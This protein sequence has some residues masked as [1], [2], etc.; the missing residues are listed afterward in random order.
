MKIYAGKVDELKKARD[1]WEAD[2]DAKEAA[3]KQQ[4]DV[5]DEA[6]YAV[7]GP[8]EDKLKSDLS[9]FNLLDFE[10]S[11]RTGYDFRRP[12]KKGRAEHLTIRIECNER[13]KF[14]DSS[15]LSWSFRVELEGGEIVKQ[16]NSWSGL[17]ATTPEQLS[18]L[19]QTV[20][21]LEYLQSVNWEEIVL[22]DLPKRSDYITVEQPSRYGRPDFELQ[23]AEA[24]IEDFIGQ[25]I[26]VKGKGIEKLDMYHRNDYWYVIH[27]ETPKKYIISYITNWELDAFKE[28]GMSNADIVSKLLTQRWEYPIKKEYFIPAVLEYYPFETF[29]A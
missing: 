15:A 9:K 26:L 8:I 23:I 11:V 16:T 19:K 18:S 10:V 13:R 12:D 2:Y 27:R 6:Q 28:Q 1:E 22:A 21:A 7:I 5:Y 24:E 17:K 3:Y 20:E 4:D 25:P 29:T 14:E